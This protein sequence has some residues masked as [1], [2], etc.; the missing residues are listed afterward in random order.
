MDIAADTDDDEDKEKEISRILDELTLGKVDL[1]TY[2]V[3]FFV[4]FSHDFSYLSLNN[5]PRSN[6]RTVCSTNRFTVLEVCYL[7]RICVKASV[8][9]VQNLDIAIEC[10]P[11]TPEIVG[12]RVT[13]NQQIPGFDIRRNGVIYIVNTAVDMRF[14]AGRDFC[15]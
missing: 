4:F 2:S 1:A 9:T 14:H 11:A 7:E 12:P 5:S 15:C 3:Y 8:L 13:N 6:N 10:C